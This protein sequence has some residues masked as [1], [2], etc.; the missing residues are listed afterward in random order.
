MKKILFALLLL[1]C[2]LQGFSIISRDAANTIVNSY[3]VSEGLNSG[4]WLYTLPNCVSDYSIVLLGTDTIQT[5]IYNAYIYF[6]DELPFENW[7]HDCRYLFVNSQTGSLSCMVY[8][9]PPYF[10]EEEWSELSVNYSSISGEVSFVPANNG[11]SLSANSNNCYAIIISGGVDNQNNWIRYW[12]DCS[13][14]YRVLKESYGY[15]DNHIFVLMS[16]GT[17]P[18]LDRIHY[19]GQKDSSPLDLDNDGFNDIQYPAT[20]AS[21]ISVF[22]SLSNIITENDF[23]FIFSTDHGGRDRIRSESFIWLWNREIMYA[24]EFANLL[25]EIQAGQIN[26]VMEQC[27]SGGFIEPL[28]KKNRIVSTACSPLETSKAMGPNYLFNEYVYHWTSAM[29]GSQHDGLG[30]NADYNNDGFVSF[31]EASL[32]ATN[33]D[34]ANENPQYYSNKPHLGDFSTLLWNEACHD[35]CLFNRQITSDEL[36]YGC[37]VTVNNVQ[38]SNNSKLTIEAMDKVSINRIKVNL[39]SSLKTE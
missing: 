19:N 14:I 35:T 7:E 20:R 38:V 13:F 27:Y 10:L 22:D 21:L 18:A 23:L 9:M 8:S 30:V 36:A 5:P 17:N 4:T 26:V 16:D 37:N 2:P 1:F 11:V 28:S 31:K 3:L 34:T 15:A 25:E 33:N 32:Y 24:S 39:G 6:L 29:N 12:N